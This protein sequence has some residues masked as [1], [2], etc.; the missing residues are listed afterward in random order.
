M[1][2]GLVAN[3]G[4]IDAIRVVHQAMAY[5]MSNDPSSEATK[6]VLL[7]AGVSSRDIVDAKIDSW[8]RREFNGATRWR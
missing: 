1:L 4:R 6:K 7:A 2:L 5:S 3:R 8:K